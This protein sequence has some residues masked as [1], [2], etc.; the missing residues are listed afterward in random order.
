MDIDKHTLQK[1]T[2]YAQVFKDARDRGA[3]ESDTVL[4]LVKFFEDVL[5]YDSLAGEIS[6][7]VSVKDRFCDFG[8]KLNGE[9]KLLV[10][11]KSAGNKN[12]RDK[13]I[14][15]AG[16]YASRSGL[17]W[18]LLTNGIEWR[19]Y[20]L[21][22]N[23]GEGITHDELFKVNLV[24]E[25][26]EKAAS[27]WNYIGML[28]KESMKKQVLD[29]Y[30]LHKKTLEPA[31]LVRALF[32]EVVLVTIRRELNRKSEVRVDIQDVFEA[33]KEVISK[34]ALLEAGDINIK[35]K[36][37]KRKKIKTDLSGKVLGT[38][39]VEDEVIDLDE[40]KIEKQLNDNP[41]VDG[42]HDCQ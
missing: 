31:S 6:K 37:R 33:I 13:D 5:G 27:I 41:A 9:I 36:R 12:L 18:V 28:N 21:S 3:N 24:D 11:V 1:L 42:E 8:I 29:V 35:K 20:H 17:R 40:N 22:F 26:D 10:E 25:I 39:E 15:Q 16:N 23:E 32:S 4:Y 7:E 30:L 14:E 34:D 19:L 38:E 2:K